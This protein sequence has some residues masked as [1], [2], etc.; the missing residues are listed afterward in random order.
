[1][2]PGVLGIG[3]T[4]TARQVCPLVSQALFAFTHTLPEIL[5]KVALIEVVPCP[6]FMV[7]PAGTVQV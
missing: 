2:T 1:M 7:V 5:P 4:L 6:E 3:A